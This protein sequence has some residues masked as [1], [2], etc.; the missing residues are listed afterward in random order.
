MST[1]SGDNKA[2]AR[3]F[4][5]AMNARKLDSLDE[6][7]ALDFVRHCQATPNVKVDSLQDFK[8]FLKQ[9]FAWRMFGASGH[10]ARIASRMQKPKSES[11]TANLLRRSGRGSILIERIVFDPKEEAGTRKRRAQV[12]VAY[13]TV[14]PP[15]RAAFC[16]LSR[17]DF[18]D[19]RQTWPTVCDHFSQWFWR[20]G[21]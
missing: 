15:S 7:V 8:E 5:E 17:T 18:Q 1:I 11:S 2:L 16:G 19:L 12:F 20:P 9:D 4:G 3:R 14:R 10:V 13:A 21:E 6:I